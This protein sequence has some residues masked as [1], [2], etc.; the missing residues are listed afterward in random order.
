MNIQI[1]SNDNLTIETRHKV[2]NSSFNEPKSL[3][4]Y[5]INIISLQDKGIWVHKGQ[6][7]GRVDIINHFRS[8]KE[9]LE[10]SNKAINIVA[11][12]QNYS[13]RYSF[14]GMAYTKS[15]ELKDTVNNLENNILDELIP[16]DYIRIFDLI[17]EISKT[18]IDNVVFESAFCFLNSNNVLTRSIGGNKATTIRYGNLILTTLDLQSS[19]TAID[20]FLKGIGLD[21]SK[22]ELPQWLIDYKCFDDEQQ[23]ELIDRSNQEIDELKAKIEQANIKLEENSKYK[24]ILV[25]SGNE[26]VS[27]VFEILEKLLVCDLSSFKDEKREDFLIPKENITFVGEIKGVTS[28]VKYEHVT[29]VEVHRGKYLDKLKDENRKEDTKTLL[30]INPIRNKP[31]AEREPINEEQIDLSKKMGS[32]IITTESLLKIFE[33][34]Q[35]GEIT[36]D[37]I[38]SVFSARTGLLTMDA[39]Y[40]DEEKV[41]NSVYKI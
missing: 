27:T 16:N 1:I 31:L 34:F 40:E 37:K 12:P 3:D 11:L 20:D 39:F 22:A 29:Q 25:T 13:L 8:I 10:N 15:V 35:N 30:I 38:I 14:N 17:Y 28:N 41:D 23:K 33:Q 2:V 4:A 9:I 36:C 5:D 32:L 24:S 7:Y 18:K 19:N 21:S 6:N 26:L